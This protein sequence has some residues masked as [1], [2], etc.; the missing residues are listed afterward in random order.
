MP[1]AGCGAVHRTPVFRFSALMRNTTGARP[2]PQPQP[3]LTSRHRKREA[4]ETLDTA[5]AR[6]HGDRAA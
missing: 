2:L 6:Q 4:R 1:G 5:A 3:P